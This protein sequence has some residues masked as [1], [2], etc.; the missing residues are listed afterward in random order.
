M[1]KMRFG[2]II[3]LRRYLLLFSLVIALKSYSQP[4]SDFD[5]WSEKLSST[6]DNDNKA[7]KALFAKFAND[8]SY[9]LE[10]YNE[11]DKRNLHPNN[12]FKA[13]LHTLKLHKTIALHQYST[14]AEIILLAQQAINE[15]YDTQDEYLIGLITFNCGALLSNLG[16][17][18]RAAT[19][20]LK[21][22]EMSDRLGKQSVADQCVNYTILGETLFHCRE[23]QKSIFYTRRTIDLYNDTVYNADQFRAR[24][25]NTVGQNYLKLEMLDSAMAY[26]DTSFQIA[27][28]SKDDVWRGINAGFIGQVLY[29]KKQISQAR[30]YLQLAYVTTRD[31]ERDH[32]GNA[33]QW[34]A[35]IDLEEGKIDS[36]RIKCREALA[37]LKPLSQTY[38]LQAASF[39][40]QAYNTA[41]D[42]FQTAGMMDSSYHYR[43]LSTQL[44]DS[45]QGVTVLSS[46]KIA[47][48]RIDNEN[49]YRAVQLLER[50]KRNEE[51]RHSFLVIAVV[52]VA[53]IVYMYIRRLRIKQRH[54]EEL[55][56]CERQAAEAAL[57]SAR[58]QLELFTQN[59]VEKTDLIDTLKHQILSKELSAEQ[60]RVI[61]EITHNT[62]LTEAEWDH[63][64]SLFEK[65]HPGFLNRLKGRAHDITVAEQRMAALTRL[66]LTARQMASIL[67][68]SVDSVHKTRQRLRQRLQLP[69][70][71]NLEQSVAEF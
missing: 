46:N 22:Q 69:A 39:R 2:P 30:P 63:F 57:F 10:F 70:E 40:E 49:N 37:I 19:W 6:T 27:N 3:F 45:I 58:Q 48:L 36:A 61:D 29:H 15:A 1:S 47:Q 20:L 31:H 8:S 14:K 21:G 24:F 26:F 71:K 42:I 60:V 9:S 11:L 5:A 56:L 43:R 66:N 7:F 54:K 38:Y 25:Y 34:L 41:A 68:I 64:K 35:Q 12:Y 16:E 67:G 55:A 65:V 23:Y 62:I 33:L 13:R 52:L 59:I 28:K 18:E 32:A 53:V 4:L 50:E 44:R 51:M 17:L